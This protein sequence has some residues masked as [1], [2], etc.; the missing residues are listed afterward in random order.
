MQQSDAKHFCFYLSDKIPYGW[1]SLSS[2]LFLVLMFL[3]AL[4]FHNYEYRKE[5]LHNSRFSHFIYVAFHLLYISIHMCCSNYI[6]LC[7]SGV[8]PLVSEFEEILQWFAFCCAFERGKV[9]KERK[10]AVWWCVRWRRF[11][12]RFT[13]TKNAHFPYL[14]TK[15]NT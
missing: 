6:F 10:G 11:K 13:E 12:R 14:S 5:M 9:L 8:R 15:R 7:D 2:S 1:Q 4:L 3:W